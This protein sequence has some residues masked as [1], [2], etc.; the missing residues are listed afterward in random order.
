MAQ[1][2]TKLTFRSLKD[3]DP[4]IEPLL[5]KHVSAISNDCI[6]RPGDKTPRKIILEMVFLPIIDQ[7]GECDEVEMTLECKSKVPVYRTRGHRMRVTRGGIG[8]NIDSPDNP[9]QQSLFAG[10]K[11]DD[12]DSGDDDA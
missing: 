7:D 9:N 3:L 4:A 8:F 1:A 2:L 12:D 5:D 6:N 10:D 11:P